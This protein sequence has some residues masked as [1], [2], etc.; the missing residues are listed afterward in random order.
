M[1]PYLLILSIA[2]TACLCTACGEKKQA[3]TTAPHNKPETF[4][5]PEIPIMLQSPEDRLNFLVEHYWDHFNFKD[6]AYIHQPDILEQA[7]ANYIDL[8]ARIPA[9]KTDTSFTSTLKKATQSKKMEAYFIETFR[10]YLFDPNSP[11]RNESLYESVCRSILRLETDEATR[12]R[13]THDLK[14]V[15]INKVGSK[16]TDFVYTLSSGA[17]HRMSGISSPY[18]LLL[19]YNPDCQGCNE[20]L[21]HLKSSA[22]LNSAKVK[23][24]V[25]ILAFYPDEEPE[26]W[27]NYQPQIP[28][29]W[30]NGYDKNLDVITNELYD[31]KAMPTL[32]LLDKDKKIIL[33]DAPVEM[34]EQYLSD[35]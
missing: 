15:T 8:L 32:Y 16:A 20:V 28:S 7:M 34:V 26:V 6:T 27:K 14:L 30:I 18:T 11:M 33:K 4:I 10:K 29:E 5:L 9:E 12:S 2:L 24:L 13:A 21:S 22:V 25:K 19:F 35:L 3:K 23:K 31:L 1:K 17:Q